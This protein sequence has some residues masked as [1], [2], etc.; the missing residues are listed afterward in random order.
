[1]GRCAVFLIVIIMITCYK[2][3]SKEPGPLAIFE[4]PQENC[5]VKWALETGKNCEWC[6]DVFSNLIQILTNG[7]KP[8]TIKNIKE[9][10]KSVGSVP[11]LKGNCFL[12][13]FLANDYE[14]L[15]GICLKRTF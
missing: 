8:S 10:G 7:Y 14:K 12:N 11:D 9:V 1:M 3:N 5:N 15:S 13:W 6:E 4:P 2:A